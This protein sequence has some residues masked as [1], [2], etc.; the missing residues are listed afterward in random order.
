MQT[1]NLT[2]WKCQ[3]ALTNHYIHVTVDGSFLTFEPPVKSDAGSYLCRSKT[4]HSN[5]AEG[6][7][8]Y[9]GMSELA[10]THM[11]LT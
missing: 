3:S 2:M 5:I 1:Y 4:N 7:L 9:S 6:M 8:T 10:S 11:Q